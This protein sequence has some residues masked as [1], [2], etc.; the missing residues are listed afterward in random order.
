MN[1]LALALARWSLAVMLA[2]E[3]H[4]PWI[5]TYESSADTIAKTSVESPLPIF[6]GE[7]K[8]LRTAAAFLALGWFESRFNPAAIGDSGHSLCMF[9]I[10]ESNLHA[11]GV[12]RDAVLTDF[13]TCARSA[14]RLVVD[15][16]HVCRE[17]PFEDFLGHYA[18]GRG[19]CGGLV[20]SRHRVA[21][22]REILKTFPFEG[23]A[24]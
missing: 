5:A 24:K 6:H 2:L 16:I 7:G 20:E 11:L 3:P 4:A 17:L 8:E 18:S 12:T 23:V 10:G 22:M 15:S 1:A 21:K 9:Q 14:R 19:V 13:E